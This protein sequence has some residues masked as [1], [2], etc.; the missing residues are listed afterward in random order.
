MSLGPG[1]RRLSQFRNQK[2]SVECVQCQLRKRYDGSAL[3]ERAGDVA[4][5]DLLTKIAVGLGCTLNI[6]PTPNGRRCGL[7]YA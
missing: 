7:H 6:A 5:P 4:M 3:Y 1:A 2:V